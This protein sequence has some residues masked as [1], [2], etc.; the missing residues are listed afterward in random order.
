MYVAVLLVDKDGISA[1]DLL[2]WFETAVDMFFPVVSP[3]DMAA[4]LAAAAAADDDDDDEA[5]VAVVDF[6]GT[7][8]VGMVDAIEVD[9]VLSKVGSI[10]CAR[11][12]RNTEGVCVGVDPFLGSPVNNE[13]PCNNDNGKSTTSLPPA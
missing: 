5:M 10:R 11:L 9:R 12:S 7:V 13:S 4:F 1:G 2:G 6:A 8:A 3:V